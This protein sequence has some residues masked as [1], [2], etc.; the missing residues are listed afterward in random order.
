[1]SMKSQRKLL[2]LLL[3]VGILIALVILYAVYQT[4]QNTSQAG[5][6]RIGILPTRKVLENKPKYIK[7]QPTSFTIDESQLVE[8][9]EQILSE[10]H[11]ID[12]HSPILFEN[13]RYKIVYFDDSGEF[14]IIILDS[15]FEEIKKEA[16]Q[17][18]LSV[19]HLSE[20]EACNLHV[21]VVTP[22]FANPELVG[23]SFPLSFC[24]K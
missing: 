9:V 20:T 16:E 13:A 11:P 17:M 3:I 7:S 21:F 4:T 23:Q 10:P 6:P 1:M 12:N 8:K 15:P 24:E 14:D 2:L 22:R 19:M 5:T 18:F